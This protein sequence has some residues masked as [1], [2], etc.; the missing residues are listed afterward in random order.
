MNCEFA[1]TSV[2]AYSMVNSMLCVQPTL[3]FTLIFAW[4]AKLN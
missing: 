3:R 4:N 1:Q 2:H